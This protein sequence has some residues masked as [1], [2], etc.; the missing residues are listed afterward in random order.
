M[1]QRPSMSTRTDP[2][3]PYTTLFLSPGAGL[4]ILFI[5]LLLRFHHPIGEGDIAGV[6]DQQPPRRIDRRAV[7]VDDPVERRI[8][9]IAVA[10]GGRRELALV[11]IFGELDAAHQDRKSTR[12]NSSH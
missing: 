2:R 3:L 7:P 11:A 8:A 4:D 10:G 6:G 12:L 1:F 9:E 5:D